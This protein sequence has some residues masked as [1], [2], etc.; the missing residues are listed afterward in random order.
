MASRPI[1]PE[2]MLAAIPSLPRPMLAR[3]VDQMIDRLDEMDGDADDEDNGDAEHID[4]R[5]PDEECGLVAGLPI[6][7]A[8]DR[9]TADSIPAGW[10]LSISTRTALL[11]IMR[12]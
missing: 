4:E 2:Q 10:R 12:G 6:P 7:S 3:L 8:L 9:Q 11:E 5:E 1:S